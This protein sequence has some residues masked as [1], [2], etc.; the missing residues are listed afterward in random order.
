MKNIFNDSLKKEGFQKVGGS[1]DGFSGSKTFIEQ[2]LK[3][4]KE[5]EVYFHIFDSLH[6][7]KN[8]RNPYRQDKY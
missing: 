8:L 5:G 7:L 3:S 4:L 6:I 2:S 1:T